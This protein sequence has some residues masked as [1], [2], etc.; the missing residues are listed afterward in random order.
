MAIPNSCKYVKSRIKLIDIVWLAYPAAY[1]TRHHS[2][3]TAI[4]L[5]LPVTLSKDLIV[6][7]MSGSVHWLSTKLITIND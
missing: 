3:P 5:L 2:V 7:Y 6:F 4:Y 1:Y